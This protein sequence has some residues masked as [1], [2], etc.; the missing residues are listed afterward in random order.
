MIPKIIHYCW[1][2][3][4]EKPEKVKK[5]IESWKETLPDYQ[6]IEW[7]EDSFQIDYCRYS[8]EAYENGKYAF[9]SD[10]AR[11]YALK[12]YGGIYF[13]T[14]IE[15]L[16]KFDSYLE[17]S[18][19]IVSYESKKLLM[20]GFFAAE[21]NCKAILDL[22]KEYNDREFVKNDGSLNMTANTVY[23]TNYFMNL[24]VNQDVIGT[25]TS[26]GI[27]VFDFT[28][29]GAFD[30]DNSTFEVSEK[31]VL[32]HHC[33]AS[34]SSKK[35]RVIFKIKRFAASIAGGIPYKF[36]RRLLRK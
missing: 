25:K 6:I 11:L 9:V 24:G 15:V 3:R 16:R 20:T 34:W 26:T 30:A 31:T 36:L 19:I 17:D 10:V 5:Y 23:M 1:F 13:D 35:F 29:F 8:K 18:K 33:L 22:L 2:G 28:T 32:I 21:K 7:N 4:N 27:R 14:D 12:E